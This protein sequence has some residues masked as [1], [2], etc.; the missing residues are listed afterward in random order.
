MTFQIIVMNT[1]CTNF[2]SQVGN[3]EELSLGH[4]MVSAV[5]LLQP[6]VHVEQSNRGSLVHLRR[7]RRGKPSN[8]RSSQLLRAYPLSLQGSEDP[9]G[10]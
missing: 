8:Q 1:I 7:R 2:C 4:A 5:R 3:W 6:R 10:H 9:A